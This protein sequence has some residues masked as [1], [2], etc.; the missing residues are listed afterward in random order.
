MSHSGTLPSTPRSG[1]LRPPGDKAAGYPAYLTAHRTKASQLF[2]T[3]TMRTMHARTHHE[4]S[5]HLIAPT[6][7][8]GHAHQFSPIVMHHGAHDVAQTA[9]PR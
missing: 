9:F 8:Y 4:Q 3:A 2:T 7:V 5:V 6:V 1:S